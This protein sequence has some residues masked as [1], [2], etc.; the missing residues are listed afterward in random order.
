M[1]CILRISFHFP[2]LAQHNWGQMEGNL[3]DLDELSRGSSGQINL[4]IASAKDLNT[5]ME[6]VLPHNALLEDLTR[7][8]VNRAILKNLEGFSIKSTRSSMH[9]DEKTPLSEPLVS[10]GL[11]D[12]VRKD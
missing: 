11:V 8:L 7:L 9:I 2:I 12:K 5:K 1:R 6:V 4:S 3:L 10:L